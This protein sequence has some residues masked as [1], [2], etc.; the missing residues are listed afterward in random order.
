MKIE[1]LRLEKTDGR[2][3]ATATIL[4]EDCGHPTQDIYFETVE[5]FSESLSCNPHAF[6]VACIIPAFYFGEERVFIESA[7]CP[8]LKDGLMTNLGWMRNWWYEP[9]RKLLNIE[10]KT[11]SGP[12]LPRTADRAGFCFSGGIDALA[13][14]RE[15]RLNYPLTHP[16]SLKD[17]L[18]VCG[19]EIQDEKIFEYVIDSITTLAEDSDIQLIPLYTNIRSL[20]PEDQQEFWGK[21]WLNQFMGAAFSAIAHALSKRFTT[22][23]INSSGDIPNLKP[24]STHPLIDPNFSSSDLQ[25]RHLGITSSRFEKTRLIVGWETALK[26]LRV[27]N[28]TD[29]Y[30]QGMLNCGKCEK[31]IRTMLAL[32]ALG[33]LEKTTAFP[34]REI[35][36]DLLRN[37][38]RFSPGILY[39]YDELISKLEEQ[40]RQDLVGTI[41][42]MISQ[43]HQ[44]VRRK[45]QR[46]VFIEPIL[47]CDR[48]HFGGSLR[49][50]KRLIYPSG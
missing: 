26:H 24:F 10:S 14:L 46:M 30:Q 15:N 27:C 32:L 5:E 4:W 25:I 40:G 9:T 6:L 29:I 31:C 34:V 47:D 44:S 43:Y 49:K 39:Y 7:I 13:T 20:G 37:G 38:L 48:K 12:P 28:R 42:Q 11:I 1:D 41:Q 22:F 36:E 50:I 18:L 21:F 23:T 17:G 3:R 45:K 33:A 35:N 16:G 8:E 19:L 2:I